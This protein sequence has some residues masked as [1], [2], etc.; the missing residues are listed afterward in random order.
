MDNHQE[1]PEFEKV[2]AEVEDFEML[3]TL[4]QA[5]DVQRPGITEADGADEAAIDEQILAGLVSV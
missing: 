2:C 5:L 3:P 1:H 4:T